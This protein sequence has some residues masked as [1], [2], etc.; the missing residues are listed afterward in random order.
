MIGLES[1]VV[2]FNRHSAISIAPFVLNTDRMYLIP[3]VSVLQRLV[4]LLQVVVITAPGKFGCYQE[5]F[6]GVFL[7]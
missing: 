2:H 3:F 5:L 7:P 4:L 1:S 6:Q